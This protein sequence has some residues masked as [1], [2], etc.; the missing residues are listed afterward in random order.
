MACSSTGKYN[1]ILDVLWSQKLKQCSK[2]KK[3]NQSINKLTM[4]VV[5]QKQ[6]NKQKKC[7]RQLK[8]LPMAKGGI[9]LAT[10]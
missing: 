6:T 8:E 3:I 4:K 10:N 2:K 5:C 1:M 7:K 9:I